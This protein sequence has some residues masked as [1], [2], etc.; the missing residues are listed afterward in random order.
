MNAG[1]NSLPFNRRQLLKTA[2]ALAASS[3]FA[4]LL[5]ES[6]AAAIPTF[7]QQ[8]T[9]TPAE[10]LA[11]MR[12][13]FGKAP[14]DAT[15]LADNLTLLSGPGGNVV[16]LTGSDGKLLVDTF[17][18][19]AWDRFKKT[20]DDLGSGPLKFVIDTHW[21]F[22]HTDNNANLHGA[23]A[24][25]I[26]HENTRKHM[27]ETHDLEFLNLHFDPSPADAVPQHTFHGSY[28]MHFNGE[29]LTLGHFSPAHTDSDI[30]VHFQKANVL[31]MGDVFFNGMYCYI[32]RGTGGSIGG[33]IA[34]ATRMLAMVDNNTK[35]VPG[36]GPLGN[37]TDLKNFRDML[38]TVQARVR[39]LKTAG[40]S[41]QQAV[42]AKPLADLDAVWGK[43]FLNSD[44]FVQLVYST[45]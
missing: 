41:A 28:Q 17:T 16:A 2:G 45:I 5:P 19:M 40:K 13:Q 27:S 32:D 44:I 38:V 37:K 29:H 39:K 42:A 25:L 21:H 26:A 4:R 6:F 14:I 31:H 22:D 20:V 34:G 12:A 9:M 7:A 35:I 3:I 23:G 30:Y 33:M 1:K 24:T 15:H 18:Q 36:H 43:G 11:A 10:Q 8:P